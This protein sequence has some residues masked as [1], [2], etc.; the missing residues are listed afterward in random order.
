MLIRGGRITRRLFGNISDEQWQG[1]S[2]V[3]SY[4]RQKPI[5][6]S[7]MLFFGLGAAL[8]EAGTLAL[9][10]A[11]VGALTE[12]SSSTSDQITELANTVGI[13]WVGGLTPSGLFLFLIGIACAAQVVKSTLGYL[14]EVFQLK[15]S[16]GALFDAQ[17]T[18]IKDV[19]TRSYSQIS[20]Y[21]SGQLAGLVEQSTSVS[22]LVSLFGK[23]VRAVFMILIYI[24][25]MMYLSWTMTGIALSIFVVMW[26]AISSLVAKIR[27]YA[28]TAATEELAIWK[29]MIQFLNVP[30]LLRI[31]SNEKSADHSLAV[32]REAWRKAQL[33]G[34]TLMAA[35]MPTFESVT[36]IGAGLFLVFAFLLAGE[37]AIEAVSKTFVF[38][39]IFFR[40]KPQAQAV[41]NVRLQFFK[42]LPRIENVGRFLDPKKSEYSRTGGIKTERLKKSLSLENLSFSYPGTSSPALNNVSFEVRRGEM[43]ALIGSSGSGKSTI[44]NLLLGLYQPTGGLIRVDQENLEDLDL[45]SW[46]A[47]IGVVDQEV[48]LL[49]LSIAENIAFGRPSL[50]ESDVQDAAR[51]SFAHE[52][53]SALPNGYETVVGDQ[54]Y[55][56]SG[57]QRQR[58]G[59]ARAIATNPDIL[60]FDEATSALD[61]ISEKMVQ[62]AIEKMSED[63]TILVIAHRLSTIEKADKIIVL[64]NGHVVEIGTRDQLLAKANGRYRKFLS[65]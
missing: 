50:S 37:A 31:L 45:S 14:S 5:S 20:E 7:A 58:L 18:V 32:P 29:N 10:A 34:S 44:V 11:A 46:R 24:V 43:V 55:R 23:L 8:F 39:V 13:S 3:G 6:V 57:G 25:A 54:G 30:K 36:V 41:N 19:L 1:L 62:A 2:L 17:S 15:L 4:L 64:E 49:N 65:V 35:I 12:V 26:I 63:Q 21:S 52:F 16:F 9:L 27:R 59:L 38:V 42:V 61:S 47:Q 33:K 56:L 28:E 53:I 60:I 22:D 51:K 48:A 40:L